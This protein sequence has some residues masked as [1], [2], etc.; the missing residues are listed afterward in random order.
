MC[1]ILSPNLVLP[2]DVQWNKS[3]HLPSIQENTI[4][5]TKSLYITMYQQWW[6]SHNGIR[7]AQILL[8]YMFITCNAQTVSVITYNCIFDVTIKVSRDN[9]NKK[10][11]SNNYIK[12][13]FVHYLRSIRSMQRGANKRLFEPSSSFCMKRC[14]CWCI[15]VLFHHYH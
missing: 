1:W 6:W 2:Q 5:K 3:T 4:N 11:S 10:Y 9:Y 7:R 15:F 13:I 8:I 14:I 12:L